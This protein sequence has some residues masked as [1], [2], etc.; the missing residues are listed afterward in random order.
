M[1]HGAIYL[2]TNPP[3]VSVLGESVTFHPAGAGAGAKY[4]FMLGGKPVTLN[5]LPANEI[6]GHLSGFSGFVQ[7]L[8]EDPEANRR[9]AV[10]RISRI[11]CVL[12][13]ITEIEFDDDL[14]EPVSKLIHANGGFLFTFN[15][16]YLWDGTVIV[17]PMR[18]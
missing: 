17:G 8:K 13:I 16:I 4:E 5:V 6:P 14:F 10:S 3:D 12:G 9:D 1:A 11:R 15:S 18:D 2:E 7:H